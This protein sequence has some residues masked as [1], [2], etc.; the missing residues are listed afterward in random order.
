M[1]DL[2]INRGFKD[3][4]KPCYHITYL[5]VELGLV[6]LAQFTD[7]KTARVVLEALTKIGDSKEFGDNLLLWLN[8][9]G[10]QA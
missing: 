7:H 9:G 1:S 8:R 2:N 3:N 4:G 10:G 6:R 5:D